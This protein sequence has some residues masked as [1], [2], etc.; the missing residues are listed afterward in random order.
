[1]NRRTEVRPHI[2]AGVDVTGHT[3]AKPGFDLVPVEGSNGRQL[4]VA[5]GEV[6][7]P[8]YMQLPTRADVPAITAHVEGSYTDRAKGFS[9]AT[10][11]LSAVTGLVAW[12]VA[13][14]SGAVMFSL[15]GLAW[16]VTGFFAV[17]L[18]SFALH[19]LVSPE[20]ADLFRAAG[21]YRL[22]REE[23]KERHRRYTGD[24][25]KVTFSKVW[26]LRV[27]REARW[28]LYIPETSAK[29]F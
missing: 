10:W 13:G 8:E 17:W 15:A 4:R 23:Q 9:I 12:V 18:V 7:E 19:T 21:E 5:R 27:R 28:S 2:R 1:M 29:Q 11:Q 25:H 24:G 20:G 3:R 16:L 26:K 22:L 6:I 14:L